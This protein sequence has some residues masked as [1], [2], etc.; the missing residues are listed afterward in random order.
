MEGS[1]QRFGQRRGKMDGLLVQNA[2]I[3]DKTNL[4]AEIQKANEWKSHNVD[5]LKGW[6][7]IGANRGLRVH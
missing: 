1:Q 2:G 7:H 5:G 6:I 3:Y 4:V